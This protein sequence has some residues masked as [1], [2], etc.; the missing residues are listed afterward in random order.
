M[1]AAFR[2]RNELVVVCQSR[3][4]ASAYGL[5]SP[6][7]AVCSRASDVFQEALQT[8]LGLATDTVSAIPSE[9]QLETFMRKSRFSLARMLKRPSR[10]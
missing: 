2:D 4:Q 6:V 10:K 7:W 8:C 1:E 3:R 5:L 9:N